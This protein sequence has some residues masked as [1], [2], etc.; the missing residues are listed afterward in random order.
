MSDKSPL[1]TRMSR[2][3]M[4][5]RLTAAAGAAYIAPAMLS[6]SQARASGGGASG[7][8]YSSGSSSSSYSSPSSSSASSYSSKSTS[9][10]SSHSR[11]SSNAS[12]RSSYSGPRR[13]RQTLED[14]WKRAFARS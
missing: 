1:K 9:S 14:W 7:S 10:R 5:G 11:P 8:S 3:V 4:L 6:L 2:R 12:G 13:N